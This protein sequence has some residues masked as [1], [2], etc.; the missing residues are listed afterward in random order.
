[1][2]SIVKVE[3]STL[4]EIVRKRRDT[5]FDKSKETAVREILDDVR[6]RG[7]E[8]L[9]ELTEKFDGVRLAPGALSVTR[10]E[11]EGAAQSV[12]PD[13]L[14][15][16]RR[17]RDR[18][19]EY[20]QYQARETVLRRDEDQLLGELVRPLERV[21]VY[22]PGGQ[23]EYPSTVLMTVLP[24]QVAGVSEIALCVPPGADGCV[25]A[26]TLA[27]AA[28]VGITEI[29]KVGGAQAIAAMAYGTA[30]IAPVDKIVGPGNI[31]V[32]IAKK[33]VFGQV[34]I[35]MLAGPS[36]VVIVADGGADADFIAAD[37]LGQAE[38]AEDA[39]AILVTP[40]QQLA[41][42]VLT[43]LGRQLAKLERRVMAEEALKS[44]GRIFLVSSVDE[45]VSVANLIAPEHLE[46]MIENPEAQLA[47]VRNAGA[48]FLGAFSPEACG[49]Y[50]AGPSHVLPTGGTAR[51]ASPLNV[52]D[53]VKTVSVISLNRDKFAE[54]AE[55]IERI[56]KFEGLDA[57]AASVR[58]RLEDK[59]GR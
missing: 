26:G 19:L 24:A 1:M 33:L 25:S 18:I 39:V 44:Q 31:Y 48:L 8:A 47:K 43:A 50:V 58:V 35:D 22:V 53:F 56:A 9:I 21:G 52:S 37:M 34:D 5:F 16:L 36:E 32:T 11:M 41:D 2:L 46:L 27:A 13:F 15:A 40:S 20:H 54:L 28:E 57:H 7:D 42:E 55:T 59:K 29:Y 14:A 49:D 17:A 45:A 30:S 10:Q 51:F 3:P 23:A 12:D 6:E 38:H 4:S